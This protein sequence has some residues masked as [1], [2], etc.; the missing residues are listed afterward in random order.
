MLLQHHVMTVLMLR[1]LEELDVVQMMMGGRRSRVTARGSI[2][3]HHC[4]T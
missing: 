1:V 2:N 3:A 4:D